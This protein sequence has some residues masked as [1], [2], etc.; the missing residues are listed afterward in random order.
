MNQKLVRPRYLPLAVVSSAAPA[1]TA[2][3][4]RRPRSHAR[5]AP[6]LRKHL[7]HRRLRAPAAAQAR[8]AGPEPTDAAP[9]LQRRRQRSQSHLHRDRQARPLHPQPA[10]R[11]TLPCSTTRRRPRRVNSFHQQINLPLRVGIVI[12]ASTS[13]RSR[14]QFE[15]QSATEFLLQIL[16]ASSDRAFVMGF[17]VTPDRDAGLDQQPRRPR[18]RHQPPAPRRRHRAVRRRLHRL[19]RQA[20]RRRAARNR[21]ARPWS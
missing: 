17:D 21:C 2:A 16:K 14:F 7:P 9:D 5:T 8:R 18:D 10:S 15:Q 19:P 1:G 6:S 13:I 11:A 4:D 12:D 3:R 20:A